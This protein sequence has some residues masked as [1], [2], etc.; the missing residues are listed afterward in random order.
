[1][2]DIRPFAT[3]GSFRN[4]WLNAR[5]HFSFGGYHEP[6]R[7]GWGALRVWNDDEVAPQAGFDPHPHRDMEI[8]TFIRQGAITHQDNLGNRGV[9]RAGD[10][11]V[12]HAGTGIVHAEYNL[13]AEPTRLFQIWVLP[14]R[15]GV[16][17]GWATRAFPR[18]TGAGLTVLAGG[19][20]GDAERG[21]LPLHADAAVLA[22]RM[23]PGE[24][25]N[26]PIAPGRAAYLVP[27]SGSFTV[28]GHAAATRDGVA[29]QGEREIVI[30]ADADGAELV[31][32]DIRE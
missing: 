11:Q 18:S 30:T 5:H 12:M 6:A 19:R 4:D 24:R 1:M 26:Q 10:V 28:N 2:I 31:L 29:V 7:M 32:V 22:A 27:A 13:E 9:T 17:P 21:A 25:I 20:E 8:I 16:E 15:R 23:A 14:D 3:L